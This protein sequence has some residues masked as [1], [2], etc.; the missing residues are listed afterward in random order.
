MYD[1]QGHV[2]YTRFFQD[3][4]VIGAHRPINYPIPFL[5]TCQPLR[6]VR[7]ITDFGP[8][9]WLCYGGTESL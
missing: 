1:P 2:N 6:I 8:K 7:I 9:L 3:E 5:Q 4:L